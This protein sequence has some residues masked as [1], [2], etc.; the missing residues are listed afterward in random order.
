MG[1]VIRA[2]GG[3]VWRSIAH[4]VDEDRRVEIALIHRP[5]YD[6]WSL[7]K[8]KLAAGETD[9]EGAVREVFEETGFRVRVGRQLGKVRY[10]KTSGGMTLPKVVRYWAMEAESGTFSPTREVDELI[11]LTPGEAEKILTHPHDVEILERFI[12][13]PILTGCVLLVRHGSA[14]SR[15]AWEGNDKERPLDEE[16]WAQAQELARVLSRFEVET[17]ISADFDRCIQT[18]TPLAEALG[19]PIKEDQ[20]FS[21]LGYPGRET[22]ALG[23]IRHLGATMEVTVVCSQGGVI[24]DLLARLADED[25]IDL[26]STTSKKGG[27]WALDFEGPRLFSATYLPPPPVRPFDR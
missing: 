15:E 4:E 20:V 8:G 5:R 24:P 2:A 26:G 7:P 9:I 17:I 10:L 21:E 18:V 3:V 1:K 11:W 14:G 23:S 25:H 27:T 13:G 22:E 6:D 19:L 16:G 12:R